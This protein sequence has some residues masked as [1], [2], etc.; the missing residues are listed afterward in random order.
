M[1]HIASMAADGGWQKKKKKYDVTK[2]PLALAAVEWGPN[3]PKPVS[4]FRATVCPV[5]IS[6][7][8]RIQEFISGIW[9][10]E[11]IEDLTRYIDWHRNHPHCITPRAMKED[12]DFRSADKK[13]DEGNPQLVY[14][15]MPGGPAPI[16]EEFY[17]PQL[18][19]NGD[20]DE[21]SVIAME[22]EYEQVLLNRFDHEDPW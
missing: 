16:P 22:R 4:I 2:D 11:E 18:G 9:E 8:S 1:S 6:P 7:L 13:L 14:Q 17:P 20:V 10:N 21:V 15:R 12:E 5:F 19:K 3:R